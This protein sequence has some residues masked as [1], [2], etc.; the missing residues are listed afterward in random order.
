MNH[1]DFNKRNN[2]VGNLEWVTC[3]DNFKHYWA[4][5]KCGTYPGE[6]RHTRQRNQPA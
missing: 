2:C 6:T 1:K 3:A 4:A 5:V